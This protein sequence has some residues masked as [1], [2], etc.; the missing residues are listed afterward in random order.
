MVFGWRTSLSGG[1]GCCWRARRARAGTTLLRRLAVHALRGELPRQLVDWIDPIP[2]VLTLRDFVRDGHLEL[3][4]PGRFVEAIARPLATKEPRSWA[5]DVLLEGRALVLIDGVDEVPQSHRDQVLDWV[6]DLTTFHPDARY[7]VTSRPAAISEGWRQHLGAPRVFHRPAGAHDPHAGGGL[8]RPLAP[9]HRPDRSRRHRTA[10]RVCRRAAFC[11]RD[12]ARLATNPLLCAMLCTLNRANNQYLPQGRTALYEDALEMLLTRRDADQR[13]T[14]AVGLDRD[15]L[16]PLLSTLA[17][18]MTLNGRRTIPR[19]TA[20]RRIGQIL[21]RLRA[22]RAGDAE[23]TAEN[24][25]EHLRERSGLLQDPT[26][27]LLEFRHPSF[28]DYLGAREIFQQDYLDHLFKNAHDPL[29]HDIMIMAVGQH[30]R[31]PHRQRTLLD[32]LTRRAAKDKDH[33]RQL[34]LLAAACIADLGMVDP[35]ISERIHRET[36]RL[37]P[38]QD[39]A[40]ADT[41]A[42]AGEFV[43]DLLAEAVERRDFTD[44]EAAATVRIARLLAVD[45]ALP[46]VRRFRHRESSKIQE[47]LVA[48]WASSTDRERYVTEVLADAAIQDT[49]VYLPNLTLLPLLEK[50]SNLRMLAMPP[51]TQSADL[52]TLTRLRT[53]QTRLSH[54]HLGGTGVVDVSAL[55]ALPRVMIYGAKR[56]RWS[57]RASRKR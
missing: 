2:F 46:L 44:E 30:Q 19:D 11:P 27:E 31:D 53:A 40:E 34:W 39:L 25:L 42:R 16:E 28:Q 22:G 14:S 57:R 4:H 45:D 8:H 15:Q 54:L 52:A 33:G 5:V 17:I 24:L 7:I 49:I 37:L 12:L 43:L 38:P 13:I 23:L 50:L 3:P 20:L 35:A 41:V 47:E 36:R 6:K 26:M 9:G 21:P 29:Y 51:S 56:R 10:R 55:D 18:W 48:A 32:G 1:G